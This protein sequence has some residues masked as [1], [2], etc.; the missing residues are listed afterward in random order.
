[1]SLTPPI[2]ISAYARDL[3]F[4]QIADHIHGINDLRIALERG[5]VR[6]AERLAQEYSDDLLLVSESLG[7]REGCGEEFELSSPP[8][9]L[10]RVFSRYCQAALHQEA[11]DRAEEAEAIQELREARERTQGLIRVCQRVLAELERR[12]HG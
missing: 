8:S 6:N 4:E 7:W 3:L 11:V 9:V 1:M 12:G 10:R 5:D 2:T